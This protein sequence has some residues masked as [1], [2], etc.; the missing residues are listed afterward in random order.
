[1]FPDEAV[2]TAHRSDDHFG[3]LVLQGE[4]IGRLAVIAV[5]PDMI[6]GGSVDQLRHDPHLVGA[7]LDATLKDELRTQLPADLAHVDRLVFV[8]G[9]REYA[10]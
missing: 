6:A 10:R 2:I 9:G 5:G 8:G 3:D 7:L 1:M 4:R